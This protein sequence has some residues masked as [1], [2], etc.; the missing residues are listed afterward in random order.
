M[1]EYV[2]SIFIYED[3][4]NYGSVGL[5]YVEKK[6]CPKNSLII[7]LN[8]TDRLLNSISLKYIKKAYENPN[9]MFATFK[10]KSSRKE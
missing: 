6:T 8:P 7:N 10:S 3:T 4:H 5:S 1:S 2:Y 9:L